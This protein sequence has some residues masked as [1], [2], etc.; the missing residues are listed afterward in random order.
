MMGFEA[1]IEKRFFFFFFFSLA[2]GVME[3]DA[4]ESIIGVVRNQDW[5]V[6][7]LKYLRSFSHLLSLGT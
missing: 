6:R 2:L 1:M 4:A 5:Q 7:L 3:P